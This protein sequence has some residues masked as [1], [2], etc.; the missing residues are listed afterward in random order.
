[1][2][3]VVLFFRNISSI[4]IVNSQRNLHLVKTFCALIETNWINICRLLTQTNILLHSSFS[5]DTYVKINF[6][7]VFVPTDLE[8]QR[9]LNLQ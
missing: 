7:G 9:L 6:K 4:T 3:C 1:M 5:F 2:L 8:L